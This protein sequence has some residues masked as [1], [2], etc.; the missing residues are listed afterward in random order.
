[1][2]GIRKERDPNNA[3]L[4]QSRSRGR[5]PPDWSWFR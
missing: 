2:E 1:L 5:A 4:F 3:V